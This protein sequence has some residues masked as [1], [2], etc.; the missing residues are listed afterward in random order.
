MLGISLA[1]L[2]VAGVYGDTP[3]VAAGD[4]SNSSELGISGIQTPKT[5]ATQYKFLHG[6]LNFLSRRIVPQI[7]RY[8]KA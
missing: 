3:G 2:L 5:S 4:I 8:G 7:G 6:N 1:D